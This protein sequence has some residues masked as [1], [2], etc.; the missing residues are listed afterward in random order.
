LASDKASRSG[1][2]DLPFGAIDSGTGSVAPTRAKSTRSRRRPAK[3][4]GKDAK[5]DSKPDAKAP[6]GEAD[7]KADSG[8]DR[9]GGESRE[10]GEGEGGGSRRRG[11]RRRWQ[12]RRGRRRSRREKRDGEGEGEQG[13]KSESGEKREDSGRQRSAGEGRTGRGGRG[14]GRSRGGE[15]LGTIEGMLFIERANSGSIRLLENQYLPNKSDVYVA[16]NLIQRL[17]LREGSIL[18]GPYGRGHGKNKFDLQDVETVDGQDPDALRS[19]MPFKS[20]TSID[21]DF[22][23]A[24]GDGLDNVSMRVVDLLCPVGRGQRGLIVA[25][26]RSGKTMLLQAFA[27]GIEEL[28]PEVHLVVLLVDERPEEATEWQRSVTTGKVFVSTNDEMSKTHV[29]LVEAV[30]RRVRRQVEL[31]EDVVLLLD[32]ITRVGRAYNNVRGDS[33]KTMSGG[34]DARAL[35]RP[36]QFF[37]AARNTETA[38]SLTILGTTLIETGSR[39]DQVIFEEFKGTGNMELVLSRKLA[40]RRIFP[41]IDIEKTGTRKE[42][43][44][45]TSHRL[46][47]INTLRRVLVRMHW[48]EAMEL[49]IS[50]LLDVEKTDDFLNRFE[51][52]PED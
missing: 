23:Y 52:D 26:P 50:K 17:Q 38:G 20:L 5:P 4:G 37:G 6:R 43:K 21:P 39:M 7:G 44:L 9:P 41:A 14:G 40:D 29:D 28:Y 34:I 30:W 45:I 47:L 12:D 42:E 35:E 3:D 1:E 11:R 10:S 51:V 48:A 13:N 16:P 31:G 32:S 19:L 46:H 8:Q 49:L 25:P 36:K 33:G 15:V 2:R 24:I 27:K 22:H 18:K